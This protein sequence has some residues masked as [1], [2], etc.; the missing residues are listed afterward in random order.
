MMKHGGAGENKRCEQVE[1]QQRIDS[2]EVRNRYFQIGSF[3]MLPFEFDGDTVFVN[4]DISGDCCIEVSYME[5]A[6]GLHPFFHC[7]KCCARVRFLY[8]PNFLCRECSRLNYRSQ[9]ATKGSF[10]ALTAIPEKLDV[11][12][13]SEVID[14]AEEYSLPRPVYMHEDR[15]K[16]Y[17][18]RF[19]KHQERYIQRERRQLFQILRNSGIWYYDED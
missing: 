2:F 19:Q 7:P 3:E 8:L 17:Q 6:S 4:S 13:P 11:E 18:E 10:T 5:N 1:D 12:C 16:R 15:F 9:Q 14:L